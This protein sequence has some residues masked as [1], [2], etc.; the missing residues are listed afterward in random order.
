MST[1][2]RADTQFA[3]LRTIIPMTVVRQL[4]IREG[5]K[6]DWRFAFEAEQIYVKFR[7]T[8]KEVKGKK[9]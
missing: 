7:N 9:K 2:Q 4:K 6:H 1:A 3:S 8:P 5:D